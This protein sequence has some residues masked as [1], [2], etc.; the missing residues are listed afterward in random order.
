MSKRSAYLLLTDMLDAIRAIKDYTAG[1]DY[2]SFLANRMAR[3]PVV[4]NILLGLHNHL[5]DYHSASSSTSTSYRTNL[6]DP[7]V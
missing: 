7:I 1:L 6:F 5:E 4:R 2:E 3:D